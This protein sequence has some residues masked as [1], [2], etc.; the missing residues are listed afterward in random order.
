MN[1]DYKRLVKF[2]LNV[3]EQEKKYRLYAGAGLVVIAIFTASIALLIA[4]LIFTA[5]GFTGWSPI[6]SAIGKNTHDAESAESAPIVS[7]EG[8]N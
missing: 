5:T 7:E 6:Y 1:F 2:E 3:G 4:G 8:E